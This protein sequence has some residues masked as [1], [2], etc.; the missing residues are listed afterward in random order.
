MKIAVIYNKKIIEQSDVIDIFGTPT[1]EYYSP[2]IVEKVAKALE[3][4]GHSVKVIEGGMN[5]IDEMKNFMPRVV[6]GER[7]GMVFNMAYGIQGKNRYTHVPAMLEMLGIPYVGS[8]P[9]THAVVQDKVMTK[10]VLQKHHLSTPK[11]WVFSSPNDR[12]DDLEFPVIVKPKMEST[13][14]GMQ[15]VHNWETLKDAVADQIEQYSQEILV[16]QFIPGREFAVGLLGNTPN[17]EVLPIVELDLEGDA[18][19]IQTK[20]EKMN[21]PLN[22]IC[23]APLTLEQ[24]NEIKRICVE[25]FRKLGLTDFCRV[26]IRMDEKGSI[27][28][29]ELNSM[30][31]LGLTG[32]FVHAAKTAGYTYESL[33]N[34][35]LEVAAV[36]YFGD[37]AFGPEMEKK[38][39]ESFRTL[40]RSYLRSHLTTT[41]KQLEQLVNIN[42]ATSNIDEVNRLGK[43]L[44]TGLEHL[45]FRLHRYPEF[46]VGDILYFRNHEGE[47]NDVLLLSHLDTWYSNQDFS[48]FYRL[49]NKLHGSGIAESKGGLAMLV[50][51]LKALRFAKRLKKIKIGILLTSDDSL[52]GRHSRKLIHDVSKKSDYVIDLKYG[53]HD[54][55]IATSCSGETRYHIDMSHLRTSNESIKDVI[56]EMC[57]RVIN[58]KG[59]SSNEQDAI[60]TVSDFQARTSYGRAPDYGSISLVCRYKSKEQGEV[61]DSKINKIAKRQNHSKLDVHISKKVTRMPVLETE[62]IK[63]FYEMI[64]DVAKRMDIKIRPIH[65]YPTSDLSH[66]PDDVPMIGSMGPVG[67]DVRTSNE[68][69]LRDSLIDRASLLA[70]IIDKCSKNKIS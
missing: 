17:I 46:D 54:G 22:K 69:I 3:K 8:G 40:V 18:N 11:F 53:I 56:P 12:Y 55:G 33:I 45:G 20:T 2:K 34:K 41:E 15:V 60:I 31:S 68:H 63:K 21:S 27:Y 44:S 9:E 67:G 29:L 49:G 70:V 26:D 28:I 32:T 14:M 64:S 36:R 50:S 58:W 61:L 59:I 25:A 62:K 52:G 57:R 5:A 6:A 65:R 39:T 38:R 7:P 42:S 30:A 51:S 35:I 24:E 43:I 47:N 23:P 13:S 16:E 48:Q 10:I 1:K 19:K 37:S 4:G 66:V